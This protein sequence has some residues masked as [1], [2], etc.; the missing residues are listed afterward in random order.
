[1][2]EVYLREFF[3]S[4]RE[5]KTSGNAAYNAV[6]HTRESDGVY[7]II[8]PGFRPPLPTPQPADEGSHYDIVGPR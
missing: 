7:E 6:R 3:G 2:S 5:P 4:Y 1:M 8:S